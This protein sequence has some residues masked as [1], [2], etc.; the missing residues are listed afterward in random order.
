[1]IK[2]VVMIVKWD[3]SLEIGV[4]IIDNEHRTIVEEF[5]QL[6]EKMRIGK[7]HDLF[8]HFIIFLDKYVDGHLTHEEEFQQEIK[9]PEYEIHKEEHDKF[10]EKV[11]EIRTEFDGKEVTNADLIKLNLFVKDWLIHHI[12]NVDIKIGAYYKTVK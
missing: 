2:E 7:G 6:Y 3:E 12:M 1:M 11:K 10:R 9:Y 4:E 5:E 8:S